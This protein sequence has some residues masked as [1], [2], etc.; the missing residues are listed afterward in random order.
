MH[1]NFIRFFALLAAATTSFGTISVGQAASAADEPIAITPLGESDISTSVRPYP[2]GPFKPCSAA[3]TVKQPNLGKFYAY[4]MDAVTGRVLIDLRGSES[5]P[6]ASVLKVLT[7]AAA[8]TNLPATYRAETKIFSSPGEPGTIIVRGGGDHTLSR[9]TGESYTTYWRPARLETLA[10]KFY[11]VYPADAPITKIVLDGSF[12]QGDSYNRFWK[13]SDRTNGYVSHITALQVDADRSNPDLT[14][15]KYNGYRSSDPVMAA[16]RAIRAA[17]GERAKSATLEL[18]ALPADALEVTKVSSQTIN[19]WLGHALGLSDNTETEFIARHAAIATGFPASFDS[20]QPMVKNTLKSLGISSSGLVMKDASG[21]SQ[22]DRV[23][24]K[25]VA[26]LMSKV[27][28]SN[29]YLGKMEGMLPVAGRTGTL[30]G[31]FTGYNAVA[32]G[33]VK[34]KSG[35]IPGL[36][37]LAGIIDSKDGGRIAFAI[38]ARSGEGKSVGYLA[39]PALDSVAAKFYRCGLGLTL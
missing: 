7:A 2:T 27:A 38:F 4:A 15:K 9:M 39:R 6:S 1:K 3:K 33:F 13:P 16:G 28:T 20:I 31:R 37:S 22:F 10:K 36:Y 17:L 12:F 11:K 25:M 26:Q 18:G 35:Y 21:L 5:T 34:A 19:T 24:P 30:A 29:S 14:D 32:R 8:M 23:T